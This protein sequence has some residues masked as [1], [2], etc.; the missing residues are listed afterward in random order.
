MTVRIGLG[1]Y[2]SQIPINAGVE[3]IALGNPNLDPGLAHRDTI[4]SNH[5]PRPLQ[6]QE[7]HPNQLQVKG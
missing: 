7:R 6:L 5:Q 1:Y 2:G 4:G 3:R